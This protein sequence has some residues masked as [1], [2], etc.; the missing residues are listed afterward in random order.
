MILTNQ[1]FATLKA[2]EVAA[3]LEG[4]LTDQASYLESTNTKARWIKAYELYYG[5]HFRGTAGWEDSGIG[6]GGD[7]GELALLTVNHYRNLLKHI[8]ILTTNQKPAFDVRAINSDLKSLQQAR[9]A[10]NILDAYLREKRLARYLKTAAEHALVFGKGFIKITWDKALGK[11]ITSEI[12]KGE[13]QQ[14]LIDEVTQAPV[15]R[16]VY[17]GDVDVSCPSPFDVYCDPSAD[18]WNKIQWVCVRSYKNKFDLAARYPKAKDK[19]EGL[20]R[21]T[22]TT[23]IVNFTKLDESVDVPVYEFFHK[24]TDSL[25]NG[26]YVLFCDNSTVLYDGP[27]PYKKLPVYRIVPGEIFG[28]T[29][30]YS[31]GF[32]LMGMQ[33]AFNAMASTALSNNMAFG[34]QAIL[35]PNGSNLSSEQVGKGLVVLRYDPNSGKPEPLQL[36]ATAAETYKL[37]EMLGG[38]METISGVNAVARGNPESQMGKSSSG[39]ALALIQSMAVQYASGYQQSWAE[40]LEDCGTA[41]LDLLKAFA[42]TERMVAMAGKNNRGYMASFK[43]SDLENVERVIIEIGNPMSKTPSGRLAL[44]DALMEKGLIKTPQEYITALNTGT[45]EPMTEGIESALALIRQENESMMD[46]KKVP[47]IVGDMHLL[48]TQEHMALLSNPE[49]RLKNDL[50]GMVLEHIQKHKQ[51]YETQEPFWSMI[52][53]E[54]PAPQPMLPPQGPPSPD[55]GNI[56]TPSQ[57][58]PPNEPAMM[59]ED[60]QQGMPPNVPAP[61]QPPQIP[62]MN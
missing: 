51:L 38:L 7:Q 55:A 36:T 40:L 42:N 43:G 6:K 46:G 28:T 39:A 62:G 2:E 15:Q 11:P 21:N 27:I 23:R 34:L 59:P 17:E 12:A 18:D 4:K 49:V 56:S 35:L 54:P 60:M 8:H 45:I 9:L 30:G 20:E 33:E 24:R 53:G 25:P 29:E 19:I 10:N 44:A 1:Y 52:S 14:P 48:H 47:A 26:R 58:G 3:H 50:T 57:G 41:I 32:D 61:A 16:L 37:M 22:D 5:R 13:D 31:D